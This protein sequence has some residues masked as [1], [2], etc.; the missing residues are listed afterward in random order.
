MPDK[1]V[2]EYAIL[3]L[4]PKVEREEFM[5]IG[6]LMMCKSKRYMKFRHELPFQKI[7][8]MAPY[9]DASCIEQQLF[10]FDKILEGA[11]DSGTI[12]ALP[13]HERFRWLTAKRSTLLQTSQVHSGIT[14][15]LDKTFEILYREYITVPTE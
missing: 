3:R 14:G 13:L 5:N 6:I 12:G 15:D 8:I 4:V 10:S 11:R 9:L 7:K 1:F 2:Y